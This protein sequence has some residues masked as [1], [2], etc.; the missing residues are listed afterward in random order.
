MLKVN[1]FFLMPMIKQV[2]VVLRSQIDGLQK[3]LFSFVAEFRENVG[4][5]S[6][7][8][9]Q[10]KGPQCKKMRRLNLESFQ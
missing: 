10:A 1:G 3:E 8:S 7:L 6:S 9:S 4:T 5:R 2:N